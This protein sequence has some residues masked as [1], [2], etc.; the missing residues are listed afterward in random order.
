AVCPA[1]ASPGAE[2]PAP[3]AGWHP[4]PHR[5]ACRRVRRT[6]GHPSGERQTLNPYILRENAGGNGSIVFCRNYD[7]KSKR[8]TRRARETFSTL[9]PKG[10]PEPRRQHPALGPEFFACTV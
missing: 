4:Y 9:E 5:R 1:A 3:R 10:S 8:K 7:G 6:G 2:N